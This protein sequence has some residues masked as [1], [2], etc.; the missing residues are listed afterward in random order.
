MLYFYCLTILNSINFSF[1]VFS[2]FLIFFFFI[3][4]IIFV[5]YFF[6]NFFIFFFIFL[7]LLTSHTLMQ[8]FVLDSFCFHTHPSLSNA[9]KQAS[10]AEPFESSMTI[11]GVGESITATTLATL[12]SNVP[13]ATNN[14]W[15]L[16]V[17]HLMKPTAHTERE[18]P[19]CKLK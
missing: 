19:N 3:N 14:R 7:L 2:M 16:R 5:L 17:C 10:I 18:Q 13:Q 1:Y 12:S 15:R 6:F 8:S 9:V 11:G 4:F